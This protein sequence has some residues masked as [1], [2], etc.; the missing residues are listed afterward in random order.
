[1]KRCV[2]FKS[3]IQYSGKLV[4][5]NRNFTLKNLM[6]KHQRGHLQSPMKAGKL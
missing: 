1:M 5:T 6:K 4:V 3:K 2:I